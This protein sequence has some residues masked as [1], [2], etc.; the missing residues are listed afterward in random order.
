MNK[1]LEEQTVDDLREKYLKMAPYKMDNFFDHGLFTPEELEILKKY[2]HWFYAL[3]FGPVP[4]ITE[5]QKK[6]V[7][8]QQK[9]VEP[10]GKYERLW[11]RYCDAT[12]PPFL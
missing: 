12:K 3:T 11:Y 9:D 4:I 7:K 6:F 1:S 10:K 5:K 8:A 2:G